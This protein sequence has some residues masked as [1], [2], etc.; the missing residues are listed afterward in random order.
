MCIPVPSESFLTFFYSLHRARTSGT[1]IQDNGRKVG[2]FI[3][4]VKNNTETEASTFDEFLFAPKVG[5][6]NSLDGEVCS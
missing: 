5:P 1:Q 6:D 2:K 3:A 4:N